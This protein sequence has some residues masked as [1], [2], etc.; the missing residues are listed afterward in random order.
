MARE[1]GDTVLLGFFLDSGSSVP[2]EIER[3]GGMVAWIIGTL[4]MPLLR[5]ASGYCCRR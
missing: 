2:K 3:G 4:A 5:S 1:V